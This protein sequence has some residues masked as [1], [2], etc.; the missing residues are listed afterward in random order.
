MVEGKRVYIGLVSHPDRYEL[1]KLIR[2][3]VQSNLI[4]C[5]NVVTTEV[6]SLFVWDGRLNETP[7]FLAVFKTS[8]D[9]KQAC[10]EFLKAGHP[11]ECP[12]ILFV[13][14][15]DGLPGYVNWVRNACTPG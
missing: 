8:E 1:T 14:V 4:A 15:A 6:T 2:T 9:Q 10:M 11:Y 13:D 12:E 3:A 7:E 5:G